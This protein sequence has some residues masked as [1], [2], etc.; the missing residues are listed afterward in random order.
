M[1]NSPY[2]LR[3]LYIILVPM[4]LLIILLNSG[5]L[6]RF[7]PAVSING[8]NFTVVRY[9][10][11][12]Y[13]YQ[14]TFLHAHEDELDELGYDPDLD[15]ERQDYDSSMNWKEFFQQEAEA[16]MAET[17]YYCTLAEQAGYAFSE[18][19]LAPVAERVAKNTDSAT[20]SGISIKNYYIAY[21]GPGMTEEL[22]TEELTRV[23]KAQAYKQYLIDSYQAEGTVL[24]AYLDEHPGEDYSSV[25]LQVI[26]LSATPDRSTGEIGQ[27]QLDALRSKLDALIARYESGV[28]FEQLQ[29]T[30]SDGAVGTT[31]LT[32]S[33][34]LPDAFETH[35]IDGQLSFSSFYPDEQLAFV[36]ESAGV[37]YFAVRTGYGDDGR[38]VDAAVVLGSEAVNAAQ[39]EQASAYQPQR[40]TFGMLLAAS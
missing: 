5:W 2:M 9:N 36:D 26:M 1:K 35:Y 14:T 27:P 20:D 11:Y 4:V 34:E 8:E 25:Q 33:T 16:D 28:P 12:Y 29:Q 40:K 18:E 24:A 7:I 6:Q 23:V 17:A 13:D 22:Y 30:F 19:E 37:A 38:V 21:Y 10:Y 15:A 3:A 39:A 31:L 32:R